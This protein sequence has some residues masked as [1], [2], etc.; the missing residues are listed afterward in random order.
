MVKAHPFLK[1]CFY[2][3]EIIFMVQAE[4]ITTQSSSAKTEKKSVELT[5]ILMCGE[6]FSLLQN[7]TLNFKKHS[8]G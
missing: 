8:G 5:P 1:W 4:I 3:Q 7:F 6:V 2:I